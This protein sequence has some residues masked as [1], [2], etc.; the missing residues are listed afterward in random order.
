[1]LCI[2]RN[3]ASTRFFRFEFWAAR[4]RQLRLVRTHD[5]EWHMPEVLAVVHGRVGAREL[6]VGE[7]M[8]SR[9]GPARCVG[10]GPARTCRHPP[11]PASTCRIRG[12]GLPDTSNRPSV[13][14]Q[15]FFSIR[16]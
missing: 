11:A 4:Y 8:D 16:L 10:S 9:P 12:Q 14:M 5:G 7:R 15:P 3:M 1:M 6:A 2:T 13:R